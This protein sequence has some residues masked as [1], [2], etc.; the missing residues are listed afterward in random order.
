MIAVAASDKDDTKAAFSDFG[1][2]YVDLAAPGVGILSTAPGGAYAVKSGTSMA[3]P[4]VSGV[5]ALAWSVLPTASYQRIRDAILDG[6]DPIASMTGMTATGGR[7]NA[8]G[9]LTELTTYTSVDAPTAIPDEGTMTSTLTVPDSMTIGD[10]NVEIDIAHNADQDLDVFLIAPDGTRVELFTDVGGNGDNFTSIN[11]DDEAAVT[12]S[13]GSAPFSGSFRP[14]GSLA[15]LDGKEAQGTWTLEVTDDKRRNTGALNQWSLQVG[16]KVASPPVISIDDVRLAEGD[17]GTS[18]FVFTVS[19]SGD[20]SAASTVGFSTSDGSAVAGIDYAASTGTV[21]FL[22]DETTKTIAVDVLGDLAIES[23]ETFVVDLSIIDNGVF[24]DSRGLGTIESD[25]V[26]AFLR[27]FAFPDFTDPSGLALVGDA[28]APAGNENALR[29]TPAVSGQSGA[30]W[31][32][33]EKQFVAID[34]ETTFDFNLSENQDA[35]GGSDGFVFVVQNHDPSFLAGG[36]GTLGYNNL[37]NSLA[38][39]FDTFQNGNVND[40]SGS[41][42]SVHT[43]GTLPNSWD[44]A[45]S[46]GSYNTPSIIDDAATH[47][48]RIRYTPGTLSVY[49]DNLSSPVLSVPVDLAEIL[50][51][52]AGRAWVGFTATTGGGWQNHDI[53]NWE[54]GLRDDTST[55]IAIENA[56]VVEGNSGTTDVVF[57]VERLGDTSGTTTVNWS[58]ADASATAGS[59]FLTT[60]GQVVFNSGETEKTV[61]VTVNGDTLEEGDEAFRVLLSDA[62]GAVIVDA[63]AVGTIIGDDATISISDAVVV[64]GNAGNTI[65][66]TLPD[67]LIGGPTPSVGDAFGQSVASLGDLDGDGVEDIA[68]GAWNDRTNGVEGGAVYVMLLN[69]DGTV[70]STTKI[71][72]GLNGGPT[73]SSGDSFGSALASIG[74]WDGN[75]V[76]D[77]LVGAWGDDTAGPDRGSVYLV[78][79]NSDGTALDTIKIAHELNGGPSVADNDG[80]GRSGRRVSG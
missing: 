7:L 57:T 45:L 43:N 4:H 6:V 73:L 1:S 18:T 32:T 67:G 48:A 38:V 70:K 10:V 26:A 25:D 66:T 47:T 33:A 72:N 46:L 55:T 64:E 19:R 8:L 9:T 28:S 17:S 30:A 54:Y 49:L 35:P 75:G 41:H 52:D 24:G 79:L 23:D 37:P 51:L 31:Y 60:S 22:A 76:T 11:L 78:R 39:E 71:A 56:A 14:E 44:E 29:L 12:I 16:A 74:D 65:S 63:T 27:S 59:D 50:D 21:Q 53:L 34:W 40:P 2:T 20:T 13:S 68:V 36:G 3:V 77:L 42:I 80:F 62:V 69:A 61:T 5:A 58:T 15:A